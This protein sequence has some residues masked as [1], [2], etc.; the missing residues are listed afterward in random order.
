M[1]SRALGF[2]LVAA[3]LAGGCGDAEQSGFLDDGPKPGCR[4]GDESEQRHGT[5]CLC[6]H[7]GEF[8]VAGSVDRDGAEI[9]RIVVTD[10]AGRSA[11]MV[12]NAFGNFFRHLRLSS[13]LSA[14]VFGP[15]GEALT[16]R[17]PAPHGDCNACHARGGAAPSLR[18]PE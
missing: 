18:G 6:C 7:R 12:P 1:Q 8:G 14:T 5:A 4:D 9:A 17:T 13:P 16:M 15:T 10:S 3:L 2:G 11:D